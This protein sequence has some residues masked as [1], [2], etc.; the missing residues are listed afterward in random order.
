MKAPPG[1]RFLQGTSPGGVITA[2]HPY[3]CPK[4]D[5]QINSGFISLNKTDRQTLTA[6]AWQS[7]C[8]KKALPQKRHGVR[9]LN[10]VCITVRQKQYDC[11][12]KS[13]NTFLLCL[14]FF[15]FMMISADL[16][17]VSA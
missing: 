4:T 11:Q 2:R 7:W 10:P 12:D 13:R 5:F 17:A 1:C 15:G 3:F 8:T 16:T 14:P 9:F 6:A